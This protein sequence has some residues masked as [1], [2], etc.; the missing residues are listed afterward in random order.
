MPA[1][2]QCCIAVASVVLVAAGEQVTSRV[3]PLYLE[4]FRRSHIILVTAGDATKSKIRKNFEPTHAPWDLALGSLPRVGW[5]GGPRARA[6]SL[7][8]RRA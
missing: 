3:D 7:S 4:S 6:H 2:V 5:V 8:I 1:F